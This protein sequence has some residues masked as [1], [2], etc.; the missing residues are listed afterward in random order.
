MYFAIHINALKIRQIK[1]RLFC[2]YVLI[3]N[4]DR[5]VKT[6]GKEA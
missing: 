4:H 6:G 3:G 2:I 1:S 5:P